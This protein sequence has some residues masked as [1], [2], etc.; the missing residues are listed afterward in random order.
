MAVAVEISLLDCEMSMK[1][2]C[3]EKEYE[4]ALADSAHLL[5]VEKDRVR[6]MEHLLLQFESENLRSQ[7]DQANTQLRG[8]T[9]LESD[10]LVQ[11]DEACQEIDRLDRHVQ[12]SSSEIE[13]LQVR[14]NLPD[15]QICL[16]IEG[17]W[18]KRIQDELSA[19]NN[20]ST[21][22]N[23]LLSEKLH[24]SRALSNLQ[25]ELGRLKTQNS[26][27][28]ASVAGKQEME[29][30]LNSLEVQLENEKHSHERTR[31][32]NL[33]Q[34]MEIST[35]IAK[36]E[37]LQGELAGELRA[38]QQYERD[39]RQQ[40]ME[41]ENQRGVLEGKVETLRKQLRSTKDKLQEAQHDLQQKRTTVWKHDN[42]SANPR[43]R[44]IPLQHSGPSADYQ[45]GVTIATPGAVRVQ[46]KIQRQLA[47]PGDKSAFSIT[48]F[49]NRTGAHRA[50]PSSSDLDNEEVSQAM[51]DIQ[52]LRARIAHDPNGLDSS[53]MDQ[54]DSIQRIDNGEKL[55]SK[56]RKA[57]AANEPKRSINRLDEKVPLKEADEYLDPSTDQGQT[58][59]KKRKLG[60]QRD[61][62]LFED[63]EEEI[64]E[65]RKPGRKVGLGAG[66][67]SVLATA[68]ISGAL[69]GDRPPRALGFGG[70]S[71]LKR[72][73]KR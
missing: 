25:S 26:S 46:E 65:R 40:T 52:P 22:Y 44:V 43:S 67:T 6:R 61:R 30:Q 57:K 14:A 2:V 60:A 55:K 12:A 32:K 17:L 54:P 68:Q 1:T 71:P 16:R 47:L 62:S 51:T 28:Q 11:L 20:T 18:S 35:L 42:E 56:A 50:S 4:R 58:K 64:L 45:N 8:L 48:P 21:S 72:D 38:K 73:R 59:M 13:K 24:L 33:Q 70:F 7:L 66:R 63:D 36:V 27:H 39:N 10:T 9:R 15:E 37:E 69:V 3:L 53:P 31:A 49:L 23:T 5:D 29:R 19:M 41:W 34:E